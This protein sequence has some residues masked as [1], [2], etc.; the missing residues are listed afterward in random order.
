[1]PWLGLVLVGLVWLGLGLA[2]LGLV[3]FGLAWFGLAVAILVGCVYFDGFGLATLARV[4]QRTHMADMLLPVGLDVDFMS[5]M[6]DRFS[7]LD[8]VFFFVVLTPAR[9]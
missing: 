7:F 9:T 8:A 2:W 5:Q 4:A 6:R 1:M 3:W